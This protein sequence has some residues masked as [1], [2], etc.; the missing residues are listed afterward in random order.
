M[1]GGH[2][3]RLLL[4]ERGPR[5]L[6]LLRLILLWQTGLTRLLLGLGLLTLSL[7][8]RPLARTMAG[9]R[10]LLALRHPAIPRA[11][12]ARTTD[13][14]P[15]R[16]VA[17]GRGV[18]IRAPRDPTAQHHGR[19]VIRRRI[20]RIAGG[21][22]RPRNLHGA[23]G[24]HGGGGAVRRDDEGAA[25]ACSREGFVGPIAGVHRDDLS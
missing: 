9:V 5:R 23:G 1:L 8:R 24:V 11:A 25:S 16:L 7:L 19:I 17:A 22:H 13:W 18:G 6:A 2:L 15:T 10:W 12:V 14:V 21:H 3:G 20:H 4:V